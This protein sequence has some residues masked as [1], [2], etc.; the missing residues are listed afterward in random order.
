MADSLHGIVRQVIVTIWYITLPPISLNH[1]SKV[2]GRP[3]CLFRLTLFDIQV[4][5]I[6]L[7]AACVKFRWFHHRNFVSLQIF[8][9]TV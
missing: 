4:D 3:I 1:N 6:S 9:E 8:R 5:S 2:K 7:Q